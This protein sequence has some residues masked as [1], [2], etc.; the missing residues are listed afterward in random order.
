MLFCFFRIVIYV[1]FNEAFIKNF[2]KKLIFNINFQNSF[3]DAV[4]TLQNI[5]TSNVVLLKWR[6][7]QYKP[8]FEKMSLLF[9]SKIGIFDISFKR[10][11]K[12]SYEDL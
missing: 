3:Q 5:R 12:D 2:M 1:Y 11:Y 10:L 6:P 4:C 8:K 7:F 9:R